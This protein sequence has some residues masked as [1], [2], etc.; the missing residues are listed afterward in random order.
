LAVHFS[1]QA[2]FLK[3]CG[4]LTETPIEI[5]KACEK[6]NGSPTLDK[7]SE[8]SKFH[9]WLPST[10]IKKLQLDNQT[11]QPLTPVKLC[12]EWGKGSVSSEQTPSRLHF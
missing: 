12:E 4:T 10:S 9:S 11:D 2:K 3:A 5:R 8:P 7:D 6:F 1:L